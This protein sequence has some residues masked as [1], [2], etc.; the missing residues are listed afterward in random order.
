M[1]IIIFKDTNIV[2]RIIEDNND[3]LVLCRPNDNPRF[4]MY[5]LDISDIKYQKNYL[6]TKAN[7]F[8]LK[9]YNFET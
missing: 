4:D 1:K 5:F 8:F 2:Y 6:I 3:T 7:K 9:L